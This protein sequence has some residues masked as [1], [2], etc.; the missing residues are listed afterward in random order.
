M[1]GVDLDHPIEY[2]TA[3]FRYLSK[4]DRHVSRVCKYHVLLMVFE[5]CLRF[6]EDG[7]EKAISPGEYYIQREGGVQEGRLP[8]DDV[9]YLYVHFHARWC[10]GATVLPYRG[11]FSPGEYM[12]SMMRLAQTAHNEGLH[13]EQVALFFRILMDLYREN[14]GVRSD[15]AEEMA[16]Y[17]RDHVGQTVT[18]SELA[19]RFCYSKNQVINIFRA[20]YGKTPME[21]L[22]FLRMKQAEWLIKV[23]SMPLRQICEECG[24]GDYT[25]FYKQFYRAHGMSPGTWKNSVWE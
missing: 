23:T 4:G 3:S 6:T 13:T 7:E 25:L 5:G 24:Y 19:E 2:L 14:T 9:K 8:C 18:L 10:D 20:A 21:Y 15:R 16:N 12:P 22:R 17:L 11:R 1:N